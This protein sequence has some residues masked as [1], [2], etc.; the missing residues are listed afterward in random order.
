M[1][2][3][4]VVGCI[5]SVLQK[6]DVIP[7]FIFYIL[8][9]EKLQIPNILVFINME[10]SNPEI[11]CIRFQ[12]ANIRIQKKSQIPQQKLLIMRAIS[13]LFTYLI[14]EKDYKH[15]NHRITV[16]DVFHKL[17][18]QRDKCTAASSLLSNVQFLI[19][20]QESREA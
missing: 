11:F 7:L 13:I 15:F 12:N 20:L 9:Q 6:K 10:V 14:A 3:L 4:P 2:I 17:F 16:I 8:Y 1:Y 18:Q 5:L 19:G